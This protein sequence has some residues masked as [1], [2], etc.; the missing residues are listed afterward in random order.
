LKPRTGGPPFE[1]RRT[2]AER[3]LAEA[4]FALERSEIPG[5]SIPTRRGQEW[6]LVARRR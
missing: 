5:D 3:L 6:L 2:E 1:L 4:G